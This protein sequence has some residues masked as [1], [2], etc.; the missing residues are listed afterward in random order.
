MS[1]KKRNKLARA[2]TGNRCN[3]GIKLAHWNAGSAHLH[4]KMDELEQVVSN[5]HPHVL[6]I[7]EANFKR[8]HSL[9][10]VQI[11]DYDLILSKTLQ[12]DILGVSRVVCYMHQSMVGKV[13]NDLMSDS[14]SSIW[15]ELGLPRKKKFL[16]C[17]LY[18][19]A[20]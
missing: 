9:E 14:F 5:L 1:R 13:R 7:S 17:Q 10:D 15:L 8:G 19:R 2:T 3:R 16:V 6:G 11:H 4:N 12:N 18:S 20:R